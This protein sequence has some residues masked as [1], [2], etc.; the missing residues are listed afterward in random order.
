MYGETQNAETS[1][2]NPR[3][4]ALSGTINE[5]SAFSYYDYVAEKL[6]QYRITQHSIYSIDIFS[7]LVKITKA[8]NKI[9]LAAFVIYQYK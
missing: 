5:V 7:N 4:N 9:M 2:V 6:S 3:L 8:A 1:Q